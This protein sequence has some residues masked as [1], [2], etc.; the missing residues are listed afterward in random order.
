MDKNN[1]IRKENFSWPRIGAVV[2]RTAANGVITARL[3]YNANSWAAMMVYVVTILLRGNA[4]RM[5][6]IAG[7]YVVTE[8]V[9]S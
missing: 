1:E 9:V 2:D 8:L 6:N 5:V 7:N 4:A 3:T